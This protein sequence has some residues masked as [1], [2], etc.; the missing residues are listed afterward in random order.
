M[1]V[2]VSHGR[3]AQPLLVGKHDRFY[4]SLDLLVSHETRGGRFFGRRHVRCSRILRCTSLCGSGSWSEPVDNLLG[5]EE[6]DRRAL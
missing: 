3:E 4:E 5:H 2:V 1:S 6:F